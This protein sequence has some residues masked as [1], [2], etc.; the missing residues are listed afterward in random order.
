MRELID[1]CCPVGV[2]H[3]REQ[4]SHGAWRT[5]AMSFGCASQGFEVLALQKPGQL[6]EGYED[7]VREISETDQSDYL[8]G[9]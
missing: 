6:N 4:H 9:V 7:P 8:A 1:M 5:S 3:R 2:L